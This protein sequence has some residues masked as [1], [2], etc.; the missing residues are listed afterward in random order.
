MI[1]NECHPKI[2]G[3]LRV[4]DPDTNEVLVD[5]TNAI[6]FENLSYALALSL[7][8]KPNGSIMQMV[9]GNGAS[10]VSATGAITYQPPNVTGVNAILYNQTYAKFINDQSPLDNNVTNNFLAVNHTNNTTYSDIVV[11]CLLDYSEPSGQQAFDNAVTTNGM[12]IFDEIGLTTYNTSTA[13]GNLLSHVIFH[14]V[15]KALDRRIMIQYT[16]R[17]VMA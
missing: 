13:S 6:N 5:C 14:P 8:A 15:Q 7:A 2:I 9:F 1:F 17:I 16:L 10:S 3:L 12:Y 4:I 11:S